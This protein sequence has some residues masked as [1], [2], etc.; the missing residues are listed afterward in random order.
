VW[1]SGG[2]N[3]MPPKKAAG[4]KAEPKAAPADFF[5]R[6]EVAQFQADEAEVT[7]RFLA[8]FQA[9]ASPVERAPPTVRFPKKK[10]TAQELEAEEEVKRPSSPGLRHS[11]A[12]LPPPPGEGMPLPE[13]LNT[14]LA[15]WL[16]S[17]AGALV[18][19]HAPM[20]PLEFFDEFGTFEHEDTDAPERVAALAALQNEQSVSAVVFDTQPPQRVV[21]SLALNPGTSPGD[22]YGRNLSESL[23]ACAGVWRP[24][25]VKAIEADGTFVVAWLDVDSSDKGYDGNEGDEASSARVASLNVC[26]DQGAVSGNS[27]GVAATGVDS[28]GRIM[29]RLCAALTRRRHA[30]SLVSVFLAPE[31]R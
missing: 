26:F 13:Y 29:A 20:L 31:A 17:A 16:A 5:S 6:V 10:K 7:G 21:R 8:N 12:L 23:A 4:R 2:R 27:S 1:L 14:S 25:L 3:D 19:A 30:E 15:A 28:C 24:A 18:A 11:M 22:G 9:P